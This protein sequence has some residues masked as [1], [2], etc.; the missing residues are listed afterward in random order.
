MVLLMAFE[1]RLVDEELLPVIDLS[2]D[3]FRVKLMFDSQTSRYYEVRAPSVAHALWKAG[4]YAV[5]MGL[6][7]I[8]AIEIEDRVA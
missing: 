7:R 5:H 2:E 4:Q 8:V 1:Y 6:W 3:R